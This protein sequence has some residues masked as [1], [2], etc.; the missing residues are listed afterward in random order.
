MSPCSARDDLAQRR[1]QLVGVVLGL[2][3]YNQAA[4]AAVAPAGSK[5]TAG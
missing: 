4:G 1:R 3:E 2:R 5:A